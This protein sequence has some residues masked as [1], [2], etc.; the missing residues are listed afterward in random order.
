MA[1]TW[2][3]HHF[4]P[5]T[6]NAHGHGAGHRCFGEAVGRG[7]RGGFLSVGEGVGTTR[8]RTIFLKLSQIWV[9][10]TIGVP[11]NGWFVMEHPI[12]MG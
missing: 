11:Q 12:K 6:G 2:V 7:G 3:F 9:F 4:N 8:Y 5:P 1:P 10:P